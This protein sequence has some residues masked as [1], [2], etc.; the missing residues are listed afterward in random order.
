M[1]GEVRGVWFPYVY[2]GYGGFLSTYVILYR[3]IR[4]WEVVYVP[5]RFFLSSKEVWVLR[6]FPRCDPIFCSYVSPKRIAVEKIPEVV[7]RG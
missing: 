7:V 6:Q 4:G 5:S 1:V 2:R 3:L